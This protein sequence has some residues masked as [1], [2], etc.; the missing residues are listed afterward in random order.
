MEEIDVKELL[1][2][3]WNRKLIIIIV[4]LIFAIIAAIYS[5]KIQKPKYQANTTV[6]LTKAGNTE[7]SADA[8]TSTDITMNQDLVATYSKIIKSN[9]VLGQVISNLQIDGL[10]EDELRQNVTVEAIEDTEVIS[11]SVISEDPEMAADIANEIGKVFSEKIVDMYKINNV[12][13]LDVAETPQN[14]YNINPKKYIL[15]AFVIGIILPCGIIVLI[16]LFDNTVKSSSEIEELLN[17]PVIAQINYY[18]E[19]EESEEGGDDDE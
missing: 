18:S 4:A 12:Y 6:V 5:F 10:T 17:T 14:P 11:I 8:V 3:I 13:T 7:N 16:T 9:S 19:L 15:I 1:K 2:T